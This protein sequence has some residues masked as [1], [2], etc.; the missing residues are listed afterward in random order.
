MGLYKE[1]EKFCCKLLDLYSRVRT[2]CNLIDMSLDYVKK[3]EITLNAIL[4][5]TIININKITKD[6]FQALS[7]ENYKNN[8]IQKI[9]NRNQKEKLISSSMLKVKISIHKKICQKN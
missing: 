7:P 6:V 3:C 8:T 4:T 1:T 5:K 2:N 9:K